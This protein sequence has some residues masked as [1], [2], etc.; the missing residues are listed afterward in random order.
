[1]SVIENVSGATAASNTINISNNTIQNCTNDLTTTGIWYGIWNNAASPSTLTINNNTFTGNTSKA[2]SGATYLI[3]SSAA[4]ASTI[5]INNNN[6]SCS[7]T[8]TA[9][10]TG[11][12]Y[13]IYNSS[14]TTATSL[15]IN[16][17][18]FSNYTHT[19]VTGSG[20]LYFIYNTFGCANT[21]INNNT[22][23]SLSLNH[24]GA[25]YLIYNSTVTQVALNVNN[26]SIVGS[27]TRTAA[28]G[29]MYIYYS[30]SSSLGTSTQTFS[31]NNFSNITA[32][33]AGTGAFYG[34]YNGDGSASPYPKKSVFN[35]TISNV[36]YNTTGTFYGFY[37]SYLGDGGTTSGSSVYN[38][39]VSNVTAG[40]TMYCLYP[41]ATVSPTYAP[42]VYGNNINNN[43]TNGAAS[44]VYG[45][46]LAGGGAGL[47]FYKNK[48]YTLTA[49]GATGVAHGMYVLS[50]TTYNIYNNL[51]GDIKAPNSNPASAPYLA[52][53]G[54]YVSTGTAVNASYNTIHLNTTSAGTNFTTAA[55]YVTTTPTTVNLRNNI[56][57]NLS[58]PKGAG[59]TLAYGRNGTA[60]TN[61]AATSNN[62]DFYAGTPSATN[63]I[64]YDGTNSDQTLAA[65]RARVTPR[66]ANSITENPT[67][68]STTGSDPT[69]L[70]INTTTATQIES[71]ASPIT[72][73]TDDY[74]GDVRN[75]T[76]PDIGADEFAGVL[77]DVSPPVISYTPLLN[78][79]STSSRTLVATITD[80]SGVPTTSPG[81]PNLYWKKTGV[82]S[83][84]AVTPTSV[85]GSQYTYD[86][87]A[88]VAMGDTV[89]YY[90]V[91]QDNVTTPN[92]GAFPSLGAG[93][94][95][96]NP[97]AASILPT[98]PSS[99]I[100]TPGALSG[101]Y[102]VGLTLFNKATG[103]NITFERSV[104]KV[105]KE[106]WV[107]VPPVEKQV[108]KSSDVQD[109]QFDTPDKPDGTTQWVEVEE[110]SWVPMQNGSVY[111]GPLY[112]KKSE[113]PSLQLPYGIEAVYATITAAV[114]DLNLRGV[115]GLTNFLLVDSAYA[116]ET[117]PIV[118]NVANENL[119]TATNRVTIKP[120]TGMTSVISGASAAS[121]IF[122]IVSSYITID[123]SN[124]GGT[125]RNLT[126]ENT[127]PTTPQVIGISSS[128]TTPTVGVT[129]KNCII[130]NGVTS[131]SAVVVSAIGGTAGYFNNIT[132]Q[133]NSVQKAY[134]AIYCIATVAAGNGSGTLVTGNDLNTSGTNS[135]RLV[136]VYV[137]GVDG[138][139]VSNNNIG[140][141]ANTVDAS[142]LTGIWFATGTVNSTISGNT[143]STISGTLAGPRGIAISTATANSNINLTGNIISTLS[144]ASS[145]PPYGVYVF[146]TTTGVT[147]SKNK[148]GDLTNSNTSG[149]GARGINVITAQPS[150]NVNIVNNF[151][152]DI[153]ATSDAS[154]TYWV[155]G[156]GIDGS[157]G[158]VNVYHNSVNLFGTYAGYASAT[159]S[160][161]F[162]VGTGA[163]SLNV[164]D[165]IFV[166]TYDNT[167]GSGDKSYAINCQS[168]NT[169]F[170]NINYDDYF[171]SGTP[172]VLGY[173]GSD[174]ATLSAW[175]SATGKDSNSVS[176]DPKF[177]SSTDLHIDPT[178]VSPV[179][180][181]GQFIATVP[182][183]IDG[184]PR[185]T[186]T[187][188]IGADE[189]T[190]FP[191]G[192][193]ALLQPTNGA[194]NVP[195]NGTLVWGSSQYALAYDV[196]MDTSASPTTLI[197][198]NQIDTT[199]GYISLNPFQ[200][201]RWRAVAKNSGGNTNP[202]VYPF[203][204]TTAAQPPATPDSLVISNVTSDS[205]DLAWRDNANNE[206][207]YRVLRSLAS[208]GPFANVSGDLPP[209]SGTGGTGTYRDR[210]LTPN[211]EY[212]YRIVAFNTI[213]GNSNPLTGDTMTLARTPGQPT[214]SDLLY[215]SMKA[216]LASGDGNPA[217]TQYAIRVNYPGDVFKFLQLNGTLGDTIRWQTYTEWGG[218]AGKTVAGLSMGTAYTFDVKARNSVD[219]ETGYGPPSTATTLAPI[220]TFPYTNDFEG[221]TDEGWSTGVVSGTAN[222]WVRGTPAKAQLN[223]AH[224]GVKAWVT[225]LTG[226]Y[227][228]SE[229]SFVLSPIF[230]FSALTGDPILKFWHN[231]YAEAGYEGMIVEYTVDGGS[232]WVKIGELN[233]PLALNWYNNSSTS[234]PIVPPKWSGNSSVFG[235]DYVKSGKILTGLAGQA[236]VRIRF[237]FGSDASIHYEGWA[238]DDVTIFPG[239]GVDYTMTGLAQLN[240]IPSPF[241][242]SDGSATVS[243]EEPKGGSVAELVLG[244][245]VPA[246][247]VNR[248]ILVNTAQQSVP[249]ALIATNSSE[250]VVSTSG[251][252]TL[253]GSLPIT[254]RSIV[255]NIFGQTSPTYRV[256]WSVGGEVRPSVS[257]PGIALGARDTVALSD[258][259]G[260]RGTLTTIA[261]ARATGEGDST[262]NVRTYIRTLVYPDP[263]VRV[264]YD[265]G[266][267]I[268]D[269]YV[270]FNNPAISLTAGV[271][272]RAP[273]TMRIANVDALYRNE[274]NTDSLE[275][276]VWAA[277]NDTTAPGALLYS[278]KFGGVNYNQPGTVGDYFTLPLGNNA[279][280]FAAGSDYWISTTYSPLITYPMGVHNTG[281]TTGHSYYSGDGGASWSPLI[282]PPERAWVLRSVGIPV[283]PPPPPGVSGIARSTRV[284]LAGDTVVVTAN[285]LDSSNV[286]IAAAS[287]LIKVNG[288]APIVVPMTRTSGTPINGTYRA[289][290]PGSVNANGN[291]VEYQIRAV[292][293]SGSSATTAVVAA[294]SY[295][296][297]ISTMSLTG[298]RAMGTN[299]QILCRNYY[300]RLTGTINGPNYQTTYTSYNMQDA[301]GGINLFYYSLPTPVLNLGD[302]VVVVGKIDQYRGL[303]EII[304][305]T[306]S[307]DV[308]IVATGR[309]LTVTPLTVAQFSA[310]PEMYE[311]RLVRFT[312]IYRRGA[313]PAWP[314]VGQSAN[315]VMY[316]TV[317]TDTIILRID[318]D[319]Q[320][321]G[322]PEPLYPIACT[323]I[324]TQYTSTASL[325]NDGY[326]TQPR[327][328]TDYVTTRIALATAFDSTAGRVNLSWAVPP[329]PMRLIRSAE[330]TN[331]APTVTLNPQINGDVASPEAMLEAESVDRFMP[332][333]Q[334]VRG[335]TQRDGAIEEAKL[336]IDGLMSVGFEVDLPTRFNLPEAGDLLV[337]TRYDIYRTLV[338]GAWALIDTA[339]GTATSYVDSR[340]QARQYRYLIVARFDNGSQVP[341]DSTAINV[342]FIRAEVEPNGTAPTANWMTLGY[343]I[344]ATLTSG[345]LDWY[346]FTSGPGHLVA[347]GTDPGNAT[348]VVVRLCDSTGVTV[349][350][351]VDR[352]TND[353]LEYNLPYN[354]VY[355]IRMSPYSSS[356]GPYVL[357]ARIATGTDPREPDDGPGFGF[358]NLATFFTGTT[359]LDSLATINPGV[360]LPGFD[361]DYRMF[362]RTVGQPMTAILRTRTRFPST[363]LN[364]GYVGIGRKNASATLLPGLF[365][366][367]PLASG[368][369]TTGANVTVAYTA[370]VADTYYVFVSVHL[371]SPSPYGMDQAGPNARYEISIDLITDVGSV[372]ELPTV[373]SLE[374]NYPNPFNPTTQ[375]QYVL[376]KESSVR[377]V[378]YNL[379]GQEVARLVDDQQTAG[380]HEVAWDG[381]NSSGQT[382]SSGLYFYR[383]EATPSNGGNVFVDVKKMLLVK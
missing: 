253:L 372:Q 121:Q 96:I 4:V 300:A 158:G 243:K 203:S 11:I 284:P 215:T 329:Q 327:Y 81:W 311:S 369:S 274:S 116:T 82:V 206:E 32:A 59:F 2:T 31:N 97:P 174:Q 18:S 27:W 13:S 119:P 113:D 137:Q 16:N 378:V 25:E 316:Q 356:T 354:G 29:A 383:I 278:K 188:D 167:N 368:F 308:Q 8:N 315:I 279:P 184:N 271:R 270:G 94:F 286:G 62:N 74:D 262:D 221:A 118:I 197:S 149:Y 339:A 248:S 269:T 348:D 381:R 166:N 220:T 170:T 272:F 375:I 289:V 299:G 366:G 207:G 380:Y 111:E 265:N 319:T 51:V 301:V 12:V 198:A 341:S 370:A 161:A 233:D 28:A 181:A 53:T 371:Q 287:V 273:Q 244:A 110:I 324:I 101:N 173:L 212:Y 92:V 47:N 322:S 145:T 358:P 309:P 192:A 102:T 200:L 146:S 194:T 196:Y 343:Q 77:L 108:E 65:F 224:S 165:N 147:V 247:K 177:I 239:T 178:V 93:G 282:I 156:I 64:F 191:P 36:T 148:I 335:F 346:R 24:S 298:P 291:R 323:G 228:A 379:L 261:N 182:D 304:P 263:M 151:V 89:S 318:S 223:G 211:T 127:S 290:I 168:A 336:P 45:C 136:G 204:F 353:R 351:E 357:Y 260:I 326:Q 347:D 141:M 245:G 345:D 22:W 38:N 70:H 268:A 60:L 15:N 238:F 305:D 43:T 225:G 63:L 303:T 361:L 143:I 376:P 169:A 183:D 67:F 266:T 288:T 98:T 66:D 240:A 95:T 33:T 362:T 46:Y 292:S 267:N 350:Y 355:Y 330:M 307:V 107:E 187:P 363:T 1:V 373:Y 80:F 320:I 352:N 26:N 159:V 120:N 163:T 333:V 232:T 297:G 216:T 17:N 294:N 218:T 202:T 30:G 129:L 210:L 382:L 57:N 87:G 123:G 226:T 56:F 117:Y 234:G 331:E 172:G 19:T 105:M 276:R 338:G 49:N 213:Q 69:Y 55:V 103:R 337:L 144:T 114:A 254:M 242:P 75:A 21:S 34:F 85:T 73:I 214:L 296:A 334:K 235:V 293:Y 104:R 367:S 259:I 132:I 88:S 185:S 100:I 124:A 317:V 171:V 285:I 160:T 255:A 189:Y 142:N 360:G 150:S 180:D 364:G 306:P 54:M 175:Q 190:V 264:R 241:R 217:G 236:N 131:S 344:A 258:T 256:D 125:T 86:F 3:Y 41:G 139:T 6:L 112:A 193:F 9:A 20:A 377:L 135:V 84:T 7:F 14:G 340:V 231:F 227:Q 106:V 252:E 99:Y 68:V 176:G 134:I 365:G 321:P 199:F 359:Y 314:A 332:I 23:T 195:T 83:Y 283:V 138:A 128:G 275:V 35:N 71:G 91:A 50:A 251:T 325:Y 10:Y 179:G 61:Y 130:I 42:A 230:N 281:F 155:V 162:F 257:R 72:G 186:I 79:P 76:A 250:E 126:I 374:Q 109:S 157:T 229:N 115:S 237:R 44:I 277:G 246:S 58:T 52:V 328:L 78:T 5:N 164:R 295:F 219:I 208:G 154:S 312:H 310:S 209:I 152:S 302:S 280:A 349:L 37:T 90:I 205:I 40:G 39:T 48:V 201:Y 153:K 140:N 122:R 222:D 249:E 313:T 342:P 133:N